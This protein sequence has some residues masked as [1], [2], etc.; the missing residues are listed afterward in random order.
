MKKSIAEKYERLQDDMGNK[1][2]S[3]NLGTM[4]LVDFKSAC[5][6]GKELLKRHVAK[7]ILKNVADYFKSFGFM[8]TMDFDNINYVI[9]EA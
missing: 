5:D 1:L 8:V 6:I 7:T 2:T 9:V 3:G 4:S